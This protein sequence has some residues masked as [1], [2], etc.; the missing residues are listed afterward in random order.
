MHQQERLW[1]RSTSDLNVGPVPLAAAWL[2]KRP[3][4][5]PNALRRKA[6]ML[7]VTVNCYATLY[8]CNPEAITTPAGVRLKPRKEPFPVTCMLPLFGIASNP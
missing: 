7:S 4:F 3:L 1:C 8:L 5:P 6:E 2:H